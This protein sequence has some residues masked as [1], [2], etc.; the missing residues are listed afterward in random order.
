MIPW[1]KFGCIFVLIH[2]LLKLIVS[3]NCLLN[4]LIKLTQVLLLKTFDAINY[5]VCGKSH[6]QIYVVY[7]G[8]FGAIWP[9]SWTRKVSSGFP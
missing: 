5:F 7:R 6:N 2:Y 4:L 8:H 1:T 3:L 9:W